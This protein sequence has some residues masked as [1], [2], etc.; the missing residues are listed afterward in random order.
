MADASN[1]LYLCDKEPL[2]EGLP[3]LSCL[4]GRAAVLMHKGEKRGGLYMP[5]SG[6]LNPD[7]GILVDADID[8]PPV[9]SEVIV[10]PYS[11]KWVDGWH[12]G[13]QLRLYGVSEPWHE[14]IVASRTPVGIEPTWDWVLVKRQDT[15]MHHLLPD[16]MRYSKSHG[17]IQA[18]GSRCSSLPLHA[19][20]LFCPEIWESG[21]T[22]ALMFAFGADP[23]LVLVREKHLLAVIEP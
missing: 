3:R 19:E 12:E 17:Y 4:P 10:R 2:S 8:G 23:S 11:G 16:K 22:K 20:A 13:R 21:S 15:P 9:G 7:A 6:R 14:S 1:T 5:I 18:I